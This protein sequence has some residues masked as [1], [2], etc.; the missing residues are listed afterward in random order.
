MA[1][2]T[3]LLATL[4]LTGCTIPLAAW[5]GDNG[6]ATKRMN[7]TDLLWAAIFM[8]AERTGSTVGLTHETFSSTPEALL[9]FR[10]HFRP[11]LQCLLDIEKREGREIELVEA[12]TCGM[13]PSLP[14]II[15]SSIIF[16]LQLGDM[17]L[18]EALGQLVTGGSRSRVIRVSNDLITVRDSYGN[19]FYLKTDF[20]R[21]LA[22][23]GLYTEPLPVLIIGTDLHY[24]L[25]VPTE[26]ADDGLLVF[27]LL[28]KIRGE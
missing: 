19:R 15:A 5:S 12:T 28:G 7:T 16:G 20:L 6:Q 17:E 11:K 21:E 23:V 10:D 27:E 14:G 9:Y 2:R 4:F 22:S 25:M 26:I 24:H 18:D 13:L 1:P 8:S 3:L